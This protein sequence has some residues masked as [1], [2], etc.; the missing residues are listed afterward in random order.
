[1][2]LNKRDE[3]HKPVTAFEGQG[4]VVTIL[5]PGFGYADPEPRVSVTVLAVSSSPAQ[6][7]H[8]LFRP[9]KSRRSCSSQCHLPSDVAP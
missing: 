1:M 4:V 8:R 2:R 7:H 9:A 6:R 3:V 5:S